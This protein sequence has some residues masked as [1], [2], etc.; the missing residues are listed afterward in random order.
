MDLVMEQAS[1]ELPVHA[2]IK[3]RKNQD[4]I[5]LPQSKVSSDKLHSYQTVELRGS[6]LLFG[7]FSD[8]NVGT[9]SACA[10]VECNERRNAFRRGRQTQ[11]SPSGFDVS[12]FG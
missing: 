8:D 11:Q 7:K 12:A 9:L 1:M 2:A 10:S 6:I 5:A 3:P 4:V